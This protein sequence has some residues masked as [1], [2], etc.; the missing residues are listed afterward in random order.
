MQ[1]LTVAPFIRDSFESFQKSA[2][3]I[4]LDV[5]RQRISQKELLDLIDFVKEK[6]LIES[7]NEMRQGKVVNPTEGRSAL[8]TSLRDPSPEAPHAKE[9]HETLER[10]C[11]FADNVRSWKWR[12]SAGDR[13]TDVINIGIGGS[14]MGPRT[15]WN[16][17]RSAQ[18]E[19]NLH[20]L[21]SADGVIF[22]RITSSLDPY[23]TLV[24]I[25]SKSFKTQETKSNAKEIFD[26]LLKAGIGPEGVKN[27]VVVVS[28]KKDAAEFFGLPKENYFPIWDWVGGRFSVWGAIG[29][30][31][32][33]ALGSDIFKRFLAGAH[34]MDKHASFT[35]LQNNLPALMAMFAYWNTVKLD[36]SSFC[37]LPYDERLRTMVDWLQQLEMES[38]GKSTK[39]DGSP[40]VGKTSLTVWGGHGNESQH[41]FYQWLREGTAKTAIDVCWCKKPGHNHR[42]LDKVLM[43]NAKAQT[44]ALV[45]R[46]TGSKYFNV[47]STVTLDDLTPERLGAL[48]ALYEH[49]T[50][51]LGTLF[52]INA[53]DQPGVELGKKLAQSVYQSDIN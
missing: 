34:M 50:T 44:E 31:V 43:A 42:E 52:G 2:C 15:V 12:G 48:M 53:F 51:M 13:I 20:F 14:D 5:G 22:D 8:H 40:V 19:I 4:T 35:E 41:S 49:K 32:A 16:A 17:L 18:P 29:L 38:L 25:S 23:K 1:S 26:W 9:I 27:H 11:K 10:F 45:T 28:A 47:V 46:D 24:V 30:P 37:F 33:I 39:P 6:K 7:F 21:A 3:G 36:V